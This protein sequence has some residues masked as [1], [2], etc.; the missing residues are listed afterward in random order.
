[1][2]YLGHAADPGV[3][4]V[5]FCARRVVF[6]VEATSDA[7]PNVP[8]T[9]GP[10]DDTADIGHESGRIRSRPVRGVPRKARLTPTGSMQFRLFCLPA[11][12][13]PS[14]LSVRCLSARPHPTD[15]SPRAQTPGQVRPSA[16]CG[17][18][19][20]RGHESSDRITERGRTEWNRPRSRVA[21]QTSHG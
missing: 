15:R 10:H 5:S 4:G 18:P 17:K 7:L 2:T 1:M 16:L 20:D 3:T 19:H 6:R 8:R 12:L 14:C 9:G 11:G 13:S 21:V